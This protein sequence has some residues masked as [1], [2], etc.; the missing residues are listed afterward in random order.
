MG[1]FEEANKIT[2]SLWCERY[3]PQVL[4]E[5]VGNKYL[6]EKIKS[7]IDTGEVPHLL[8]YGK[9]GG[10]KTTLAKLIINGIDCDSIIIN[11]SDDNNVET[12]RNKIKGFV[13]TV[14]FKSVKIIVLDEVDYMTTN[15]QGILR[16]LMESFSKNSRFILT[17]NYLDKVLDPIQSRCQAFEILPPNKKDIEIHIG[18]ILKFENVNFEQRALNKIIDSYYPDIRKIINTCQLNS[19]NNKL[20]LDI[21]NLTELDIKNKIVDI[22]KSNDDKRNK[23]LKAR[24]AISD[25][26]TQDF[27]ELYTHLYETVE[28]YANQNPMNV[29]NLIS[30]GQYKDAVVVDKEIVFIST[31]IHIINQV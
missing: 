28:E 14:G 12:V 4:D 29:I 25:A 10:G 11:A 5:Y 8:F 15:A 1:I 30:E 6:K 2:N 23:Y 22:L 27:S 24:K 18:K 9:A 20:K 3:R 7:F 13:T 21:G 19:S 26:R 31:L 17:C 16:N